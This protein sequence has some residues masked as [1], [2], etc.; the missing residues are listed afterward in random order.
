MKKRNDESI[1]PDTVFSGRQHI[2]IN[3]IHII[4]D[5]L[6]EELKKR[7]TSCN[8]IISKYLFFLNISEQK[9]TEVCDGAK[10]LIKLYKLFG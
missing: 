7:K 5:N 1:E 4:Y 2:K 3:T 6:K 9:T 10:Q 8:D